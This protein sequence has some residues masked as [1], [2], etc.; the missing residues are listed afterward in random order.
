MYATILSATQDSRSSFITGDLLPTAYMSV[1]ETDVGVICACMP[2]LQ[3][4]L[5]RVAPRIFGS[6]MRPTYASQ[7][8]TYRTITSRAQPN[9][10]ITKTVT[11]TIHAVSK[12]TDSEIELVQGVSER[13]GEGHS[14]TTTTSPSSSRAHERA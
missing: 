4:L 14:F 8:N 11:H 5:R 7:S 6:T 10:I 2:A 1:L 9:H 12:D 3:F 13:G